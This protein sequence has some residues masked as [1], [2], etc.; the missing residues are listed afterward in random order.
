LQLGALFGGEY[1]V[2]L[3]SGLFAQTQHLDF[4][5]IQNLSDSLLLRF[6][7]IKFSRHSFD[8]RATTTSL[9]T[10]T[11]AALTT[12]ASFGTIT[13]AA[14]LSLC[15]LLVSCDSADSQRQRD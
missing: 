15:G 7:E 9:A 6:V 3:L 8:G 5:A 1:A 10:I 11:W 12:F 4:I 13:I 2:D 14:T